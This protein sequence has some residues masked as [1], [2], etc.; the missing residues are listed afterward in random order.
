VPSHSS[1]DSDD[2]DIWDSATLFKKTSKRAVTE[3]EIESEE[4]TPERPLKQHK[5]QDAEAPLPL[6]LSRAC[7]VELQ[8]RT[9]AHD[10]SSHLSADPTTQD[11]GSP[12]QEA[13]FKPSES[14]I[15][16][17]FEEQLDEFSNWL[18]GNVE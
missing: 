14:V 4:V 12:S 17:D 1:I 6:N 18:Q 11:L 10:T 5:P 8:T 7:A 2:S 13:H 3:I 9:T 16:D 15:A